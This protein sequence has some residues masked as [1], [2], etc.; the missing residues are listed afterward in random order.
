LFSLPG[1]PVIYYGDEIGMGDNI[2]LGD[3][4][5]VRTPMQWNAELNAGFSR[6]NPQRLYLPVIIDPDYH[7]Q[8]VN[9]QAQQNNPNSLLWWMKRLIALRKQY[10]AFGR[11]TVEFL[12]PDNP[13][14]LAFVRRFQDERILVV[15]NLSRFIQA[16]QL[17]LSGFKGMTPVEM[18]GR[19]AFPAVGDL[20]YFL[21]L[22]PHAFYWFVLEAQ[23]A[24][25][26]AVPAQP[27]L[28]AV[29]V[30]GAWENVLRGKARLALESIL[31]GYLMTRH[32]FGGRLRLVQTARILDA[33][34]IPFDSATGYLAL[35]QV[36]YK[37]EDV[38]LYLLSLAFAPV[39]RQATPG[40]QARDSHHQGAIARLHLRHT[41]HDGEA[42]EGT[43]YE[44]VGEAAF[45]RAL[46]EAVARGRRF[47]G[48]MGEV[49]GVRTTDI[50]N[51]WEPGQPVPDATVMGGPRTNTSL[52]FGNRWLLKVFRRIE[53]GINPELEIGRFL[54]EQTSFRNVSPTAGALHYQ[55]GRS[56]SL[57]LGILHDFIP[58]EG[59][60]WQY[61]VETLGRYFERA[62][63]ERERAN[64]LIVPAV[65]LVQLI[66]AEIAPQAVELIG[67]YLESARLLGQRTAELHLALASVPTDPAFAPEPMTTLYQ[68]SLYQSLRSQT[69]QT[70][71]ML[72]RRMP[73]LPEEVRAMAQRLVSHEE[74]ILSRSRVVYER[75]I[76]AARIRVHGDYHLTQVLYTGRDFVIIGF[77]GETH[78]PISQRRLKR[79]P[80]RDVANMLRSF[81]Y[82]TL[83][84]LTGGRFRQEDIPVLQPW[85]PFWYRWVWVVFLKAYFK[86]AGDSALL[87]A[88][89]EERALLLGFY[90]FKRGINELRY[91][92]LNFP[93]RI[94]IPVEGL[95]QMVEARIRERV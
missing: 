88:A 81:H 31:P 14:V 78:R 64:D 9:V 32:W 22:G 85:V 16:A 30:S 90:I 84:A 63:T 55:S 59:T 5:G 93:E 43:L 46:L 19:N 10:R 36:Q 72:R 3:R 56:D 6:A 89:A 79:S 82:A 40:E 17:D 27:E 4:N 75:K 54:T 58:N 87:P 23:Q 38:E 29:R 86:T 53:E 95:L 35:V 21:T 51:L 76:H 74:D 25:A 94:R 42:E 1:T 7:Y 71:E 48:S 57:T 8:S 73:Q 20:P 41:P 70:L 91:D 37:E 61:T 66:D 44:P 49:Q 13:R 67:S 12:Y 34:P 80:L 39:N 65:Q 50:R 28:P 45:S 18:F 62:L 33:V 68:R 47:K 24:P 26:T 11:G 77:E 83:S 60:A 52:A 2:Y 92:M 69:R 15:A